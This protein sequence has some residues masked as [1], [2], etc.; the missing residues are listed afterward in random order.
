MIDERDDRLRRWSRDAGLEPGETDSLAELLAHAARASVAEEG[1][2]SR[3]RIVESAA[4]DLERNTRRSYLLRVV[5]A[6]AALLVPVPVVMAAAVYAL[7]I[8]H[9]IL[10]GLLTEAAATVL[11]GSYTAMAV[12]LIASAC[13]AVPVLVER[14]DPGAYATR[15]S[16]PIPV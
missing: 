15:P 6:L 9:S 7:P 5:R 12:L 11:L 3:L 14:A 1:I 13:A 16:A 8:V 10:S 4:F 2:G